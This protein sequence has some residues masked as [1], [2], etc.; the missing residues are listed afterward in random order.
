V[1][2]EL[3]SGADIGEADVVDKLKYTWNRIFANYQRNYAKVG[4]L[5]IYTK[6]I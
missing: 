2:I 6:L 5:L 4:K 1:G 3:E